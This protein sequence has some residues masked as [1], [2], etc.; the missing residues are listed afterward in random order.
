MTSIGGQ[1]FYGCK[2]LS[3]LTCQATIPP[4]VGTYYNDGIVDLALSESCSIYV[5][6]SAVS[7]YKSAEGWNK[8]S[9]YFS[10][11]N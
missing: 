6:K 4:Y 2:N 9:N 7:A 1:C 8:Y 3:K 5:P 10:I 11:E